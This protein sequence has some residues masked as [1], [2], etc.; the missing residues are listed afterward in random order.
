MTELKLWDRF[1]EL[2]IPLRIGPADLAE[3]RAE[4][5]GIHAWFDHA[6]DEGRS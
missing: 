2:G 1:I 4:V 3:A 5:E 6:P